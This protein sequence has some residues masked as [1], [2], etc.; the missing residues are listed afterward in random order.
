MH[1]NQVNKSHDGNVC[2]LWNQKLLT[3]RTIPNNKSDF[4]IRDNKQGTFLLINFAVPRN[5]KVI[6][7]EAEKILQYKDL[8]IE[9]QRMW[10]VEE[11]V[12]P[13]IIGANW[14]HLKITLDHTSAIYRG[15]HEIRNC[16]KRPYRALYTYCGKR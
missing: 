3:D 4:I 15:K 5:G 1:Q 8:I 7:R 11:K 14:N 2:V 13:V 6:K 10:N 9:I 16:K 12:I